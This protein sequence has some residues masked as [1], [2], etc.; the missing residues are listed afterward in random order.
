MIN[1]EILHTELQHL[2]KILGLTPVK[3]SQYVTPIFIIPKKEGNVRLIT[4]YHRIKQKWFI[5]LDNLPR[6][7]KNMQQL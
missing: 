7:G 4:D 3:Q 2:V 5:N 1:K 6:I